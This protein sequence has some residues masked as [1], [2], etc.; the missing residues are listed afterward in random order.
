MNVV[1]VKTCCSLQA[2]VGRG[3]AARSCSA[4][5]SAG[6]AICINDALWRCRRC[7]RRHDRRG[8]Q[9]RGRRHWML[10]ICSAAT[11]ARKVAARLGWRKIFAHLAHLLVRIVGAFR[12]LPTLGCAAMGQHEFAQEAVHWKTVGV[13]NRRRHDIGQ[14]SW[15]RSVRAPTPS[16]PSLPAMWPRVVRYRRR[17]LARRTA[18]AMPRAA[19]GPGR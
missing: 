3:T 13:L 9:F 1:I 19:L 8:S 17:N 15:C 7:R 10:L 18:P 16:H 11:I 2:Q 5:H 6:R 12:P 14:E 4:E